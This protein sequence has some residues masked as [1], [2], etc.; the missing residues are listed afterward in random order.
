MLINLIPSNG[1]RINAP[2]QARR[3]GL[4]YFRNVTEIIAVMKKVFLGPAS[5]RCVRVWNRAIAAGC[6]GFSLPCGVDDEA[7]CS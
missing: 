6:P 7:V 2:H 4:I 5:L 1:T 3:R